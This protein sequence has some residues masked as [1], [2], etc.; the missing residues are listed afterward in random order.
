[1][2]AEYAES[3]P[4]QWAAEWGLPVTLGLV[5]VLAMGLRR[6]LG[7][8]RS[9]ERAGALAAVASIAVH[10][11]VDFSLELVGVAVVGSA[12]LAAA[13]G[14]RRQSRTSNVEAPEPLRLRQTAAPLIIAGA[15]LLLVLAPSLVQ[16]SVR[17]LQD[18]L[19]GAM[20]AGERERFRERLEHGLAL[21]PSEPIF[22]LLAAAEGVRNADPSAVEWINRSME[23]APG[24]AGPHVL[25]ARW[26]WARGAENQAMLEAREAAS[27]S[28]TA[29]RSFLC[30]KLRR[31]PN[32]THLWTR[33]TPEGPMR[34]PFLQ[35]AIRCMPPGS[36]A[37]AKLDAMLLEANPGAL[38]P[39]LRQA[40]RLADA[41]KADQAVRRLATLAE[42]QPGKSEV[43]LALARAQV[44][45]GEPR[46]AVASV[47]RAEQLR[48]D[49]VAVL[50]VRARA[51]AALEDFEGMRDTLE[52]L[53]GLSGA[54]A[55]RVA[56]A[57][58]FEGDLWQQAGRP[59]KAVA[60]Y[61]R[62]NRVDPRRDRLERVAQVAE[63]MGD[64]MQAFRIYLEL[65][66]RFSDVPRFC[67]ARDRL[68]RTMRE[69][70]PLEDAAGPNSE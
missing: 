12:V 38:R 22:P 16:G 11:L 63:D 2:R 24:W 3:F 58:T 6:A 13:V 29:P 36:D 55:G 21:H 4:V 54:S 30:A 56:K 14:P 50:R 60:A 8:V 34:V 66:Q 17:S 64:R 51:Q 43:W 31:H 39:R 23:L 40:R 19:T 69:S 53:R 7:K 33:A 46:K 48:G 28:P 9:T 10:E 25:A 59:A 45:A 65:C 37:A 1:H 15:V 18:E 68:R 26:L 49:R 52:Q 42:R 47:E 62:A 44:A 57:L 61:A 41:G 32:A 67:E 35:V 5:G 27:R 20:Q 70:I